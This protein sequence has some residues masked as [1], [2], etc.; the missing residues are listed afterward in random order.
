MDARG[1]E[2]QSRG[3]SA[4]IPITDLPGKISPAVF[5]LQCI[6]SAVNKVSDPSVRGSA[7]RSWGA[8]AYSAQDKGFG[9]SEGWS[10]LENAK[11]TAME[12]C[13]KHSAKCKLWLWYDHEC[14]AIAADGNTVAWGTATAKSNAERRAL[15]EC[16]KAGGKKCVISVSQ[17]SW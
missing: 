11:K 15:M 14:G 17:C 2:Y 8:I 4:P 7:L 6:G 10:D 5:P 12:N 16:K 1:V 13:E 9:Y 3:V